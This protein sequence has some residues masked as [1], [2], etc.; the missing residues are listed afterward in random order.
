MS[1]DK[2]DTYEKKEKTE[3][4][5]EIV[6]NKTSMFY[7]SLFSIAGVVHRSEFTYLII[8]Y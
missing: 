1:R 2:V 6:D 3:E 5:C 4:K 8:V 7:L